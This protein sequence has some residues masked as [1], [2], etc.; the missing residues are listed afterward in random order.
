MECRICLSGNFTK[1]NPLIVPCNCKGSIRYTHSDCIE[2]WIEIKQ[3]VICELCK[4]CMEVETIQYFSLPVWFDIFIYGIF[5]FFTLAIVYQFNSFIFIVLR[6]HTFWDCLYADI[7]G[8]NG[9]FDD[10]Q[11]IAIIFIPITN[12]FLYL[13]FEDDLIKLPELVYY[14]GLFFGFGIWLFYNNNVTFI[15]RVKNRK[16][17]LLA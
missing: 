2:K 15:T 16:V 8:L 12:M 5:C 11:L 6:C 10:M 7:N 4:G 1:K 14:G 9:L 17:Y 13:K 3:D